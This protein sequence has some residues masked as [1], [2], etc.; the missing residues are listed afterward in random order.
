MFPL[1]HTDGRLSAPGHT[2][3]NLAWR[4]GEE[5]GS[6]PSSCSMPKDGRAAKDHKQKAPLGTGLS[7]PNLKERRPRPT[8]LAGEGIDEQERDHKAQND[9]LREIHPRP[10][11]LDFV[12]ARY[13][14]PVRSPS[15][16]RV[17][18]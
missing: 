10:T 1:R 2:G 13:I 7:H 12:F 18:S 4:T 6:A 11:V 9:E 5:K 3:I 8:R 16:L 15:G 17:A 14:V